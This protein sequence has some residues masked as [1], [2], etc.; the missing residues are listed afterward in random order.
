MWWLMD[1]HMPGS[2]YVKLSEF[3]K[4]RWEIQLGPKKVD[5]LAR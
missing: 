5:T 2:I 3:V 4:G 1:A